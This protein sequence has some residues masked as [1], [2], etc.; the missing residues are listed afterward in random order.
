M[1]PELCYLVSRCHWVGIRLDRVSY[2]MTKY[3]PP[4][5]RCVALA[6]DICSAKHPGVSLGLSPPLP[7]IPLDMKYIPFSLAF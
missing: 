5:T 6:E 1:K 3:L 7:L 2:L 4:E